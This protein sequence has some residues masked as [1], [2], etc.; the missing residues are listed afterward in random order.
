[1]P[2]S[3]VRF[4]LS[5]IFFGH[6]VPASLALHEP[7]FKSVPFLIHDGICQ[8]AVMSAG[9]CGRPTDRPFTVTA[10]FGGGGPCDT[11][12]EVDSSTAFLE[13]YI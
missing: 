9:R 5:A 4:R 13:L 10:L 1:M 12:Q 6:F 7:L 2:R 11:E 3:S 8:T